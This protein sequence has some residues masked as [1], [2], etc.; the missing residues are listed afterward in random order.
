MQKE[1]R[2]TFS[3][4][5]P[6]EVVWEYLTKKELIAEWLMEN[7]FKLQLGHK[8]TF[9]TKP[10]INLGFDGTVYCE[11]LEIIPLQK[12]S[13]SWKGGAGAKPLL[14]SIVVWTLTPTA[15]GTDLLLEHKGF[16]GVKNYLPYLIMN[17][18]WQKIG[19]RIGKKMKERYGISAA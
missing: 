16:K 5:H 19:K 11:V 9:K 17:K 13:Y 8:F 12:L 10:K 1:I 6:P 2:H 7:D 3:F 15:T 4:Q 18:G 14:D